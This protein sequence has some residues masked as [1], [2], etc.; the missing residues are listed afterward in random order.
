MHKLLTHEP[1]AKGLFNISY[2]GGRGTFASWESIMQNDYAVTSL[3]LERMRND[4]QMTVP[5]C[6]KVYTLKDLDT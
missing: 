1:I 3:F 6:R 2:N 5:E 4:Y